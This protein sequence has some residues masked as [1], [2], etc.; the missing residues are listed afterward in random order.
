[1]KA[2]VH[3]NTPNFTLKRVYRTFCTINNLSCCHLSIAFRSHEQVQ[4]CA[5]FQG[6]MT[7]TDK[8]ISLLVFYTVYDCGSQ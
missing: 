4:K 5:G 7:S 6:F 2:A 1:M 8:I 3:H